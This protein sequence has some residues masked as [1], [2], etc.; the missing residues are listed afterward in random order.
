MRF[1][2]LQIPNHKYDVVDEWVDMMVLTGKLGLEVDV[3]EA[4]AVLGELAKVADKVC[5]ERKG[6][7]VSITAYFSE[8]APE[9]GDEEESGKE[10]KG[11]SLTK[12]LS[13]EVK[14]GAG[15]A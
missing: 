12:F 14:D 8:I 7:M 4:G 9:E 1:V 11:V 5:A 10:R 13:K 2:L 3:A 6:R 15:E